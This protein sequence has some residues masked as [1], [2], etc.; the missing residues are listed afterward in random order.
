MSVAEVTQE[1]DVTSPGGVGMFFTNKSSKPLQWYLQ[2]DKIVIVADNDI[3]GSQ[4]AIKLKQE[5]LE[6]TPDI[7]LHLA[8]TDFNEEL[9]HGTLKE[10]LASLGLF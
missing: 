1:C 10:T 5:L 9:C 8:E 7:R 4:A 3:P 6:V 2:Y